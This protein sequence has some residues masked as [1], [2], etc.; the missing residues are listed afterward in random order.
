MTSRDRTVPE[1]VGDWNVAFGAVADT[2]TIP[3]FNEAIRILG[4]LPAPVAEDGI[5]GFNE[6]ITAVNASLALA[7]LVAANNR[8]AAIVAAMLT[9]SGVSRPVIAEEVDQ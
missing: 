7:R 4:T 9:Q 8:T 5:T 2:L 3:Q 6:Y 1:K